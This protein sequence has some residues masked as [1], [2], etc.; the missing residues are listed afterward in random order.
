MLSFLTLTLI[1][2]FY[3]EA[4]LSPDS[5]SIKI[6]WSAKE[7]TKKIVLSF[8]HK[9]K[10]YI[11][12]QKPNFY[13]EKKWK[14]EFIWYSKE[15][16]N[17]GKLKL[18]AFYEDNKIEEVVIPEKEIL[19]RDFGIRKEERYYTN[20]WLLKEEKNGDNYA[21]R[22][23][24]YDPQNTSYY[25]FPLC[26][27]LQFKWR[28]NWPYWGHSGVTMISGC[29]GYGKL[30]IGDG[31]NHVQAVDLETGRIIWRR[32]V[33]SNV[34]TCA[35]CVGESLLLVGCSI[36]FTDDT[37]FYALDPFTGEI[38][39]G[40]VLTTVE[41]SPI[42]VDTF[43][44]VADLGL[45]P[46]IYAF[47][48]RGN[49]LWSHRVGRWCHYPA[50]WQGKV[51]H[52]SG[53]WSDSLNARNF[54]TGELLWKFKAPMDINYLTI[55][56]EK[57]FFFYGGM[58][59]TLLA[60]DAQ[61]GSLILKIPTPHNWEVRAFDKRILNVRGEYG[62]GDTIFTNV[63]C[64]SAESVFLIWRKVLRPRRPDGGSSSPAITTKNGIVWV[65][66][67]DF[68]YLLKGESGQVID[69]VELPPTNTW[70]PSFFLPI[71][72][73]N[74]F[75]GGHRD[76]I[77]V[78]E[79]DTV[80]CPDNDSFRFYVY[81]NSGNVFFYLYLPSEQNV[82]LKL[83]DLSGRFLGSVYKGFLLKGRHL[84]SFDSGQL[85]SGIYFA[86]LKTT[87]LKKVIKIPYMG[88]RR[89]NA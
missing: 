89:K 62:A 39:W 61:S 53:E 50:Y 4:F 57:V 5:H 1:F 8:I 14:D 20:H 21:W 87:N 9:E 78:Y 24:G 26:S 81:F 17:G 30:F 67:L 33:T 51:F 46:M 25:P 28:S 13:S 88:K 6:I 55:C 79:A 70:E 11:V 37:T 52:T 65:A 85:S 19:V 31:S 64:L 10:E 32:S 40:K 43:V 15:K 66:N 48:I 72:Y 35:L 74:Y 38:K 18:V 12:F 82:S 34:W 80:I 16:W 29:A 76:F 36:G 77:Y 49:L 69:T 71:V 45:P 23:V 75:I 41:F 22:M 56:D 60:V 2:N 42:I 7:G 83:Y 44:Y 63:Y 84:L 3:S 54:I 58:A 86:I 27:P 73:K 47:T 59:D 68:L